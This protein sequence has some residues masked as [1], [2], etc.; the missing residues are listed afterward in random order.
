MHFMLILN[1]IHGYKMKYKGDKCSTEL[2]ECNCRLQ[3]LQYGTGDL[4]MIYVHSVHRDTISNFD[5]MMML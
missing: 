1:G 2:H 3:A 5:L 4:G